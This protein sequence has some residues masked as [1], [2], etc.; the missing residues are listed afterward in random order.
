M[1]VV[2]SSGIE[3]YVSREMKLRILAGN[4]PRWMLNHIRSEYIIASHLAAPLWI[5]ASAFKELREQ[6]RKETARSG[7]WHVLDHDIPVSHPFV[8]GLTVPW[9][10]RVV[11]HTVNAHKSNKWHPDQ[12]CFDLPHHPHQHVLPL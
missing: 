8:C 6:V 9:N 12:H 3:R 11:P 2:S 5:K 1:W 7:I 10:M 4:T